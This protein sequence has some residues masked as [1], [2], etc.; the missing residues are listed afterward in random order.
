MKPTHR[1]LFT[2]TARVTMT[3]DEC[4][5][6]IQVG[7]KYVVLVRWNGQ[8]INIFTGDEIDNDLESALNMKITLAL[9][10][11][12]TVTP[13][14]NSGGD[15]DRESWVFKEQP[16]IKVLHPNGCGVSNRPIRRVA[17]NVETGKRR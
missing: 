1:S 13:V 4:K 6:N 11:V 5:K 8:V 15:E 16:I 12:P 14:V 3:C 7:T 17:G 9:Y 2:G 10:P